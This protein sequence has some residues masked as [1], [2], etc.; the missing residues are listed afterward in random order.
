ML[1]TPELSAVTVPDVPTIATAGAPLLHVPPGVVL[2]RRV[3]VPAH[4]AI[5]VA[6]VIAA[7]SAYAVTGAVAKQL[8]IV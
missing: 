5:A 2:L 6:G 7:G 1:A 4:I 3:P 8:P